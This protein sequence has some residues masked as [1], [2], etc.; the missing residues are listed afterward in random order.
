VTHLKTALASITLLFAA[1]ATEV[2]SN[3]QTAAE[4]ESLLAD[5]SS[6]WDDP[7]LVVCWVTPGFATQKQW[8]REAVENSWMR[9]TRLVF[10]GWGDCTDPT[11]VGIHITLENGA[12]PAGAPANYGWPRAE[13]HVGRDA[14]GLSDIRL[15]F[16]FQA[17]AANFGGCLTDPAAQESCIRS[18][19]A[20]EFGHA[21]GFAHEQDRRQT[22][23][24]CVAQLGQDYA[25][26]GQGIANE[27]DLGPFD[28][29]S[30]M[31]YCAS[32]YNND[33]ILSP[34]DVF[35]AQQVY[36]AKAAGS[37][38]SFDGRCLDV[39]GG[40][41]NGALMQTYEC[42]GGTHFSPGGIAAPNQRWAFVPS[43][44]ILGLFN[45]TRVLDVPRNDATSGNRLQLFD[46]LGTPGQV[47]TMPSVLLR[48]MGGMCVGPTNA[49]TPQFS[50]LALFKCDPLAPSAGMTF[51]VMPNG[52]LVNNA[53]GLC[54]HATGGSG[55]RL[56]L[57]SCDG[58]S[59]QSF[60][61]T[62]NGSLQAFA[63]TQNLCLDVGLPNDD[64]GDFFGVDGTSGYNRIQLYTCNNQANQ[65][66][67]FAGPIVGQGGKCIDVASFG[68]DNGTAVQLW[69]CNGAS[70]QVW[71]LSW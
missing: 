55:A 56:E 57:Q 29:E 67:S 41:Q 2:D 32:T 59:N 17:Q 3:P 66:F 22:S 51:N 26:A 18:I 16:D 42:L 38:V 19:A 46:P 27:W 48:G 21:L 14:A 69:D 71:E 10:A 4:P 45:S 50:E 37:L 1:C 35:Y 6:I 43:T 33:G 64:L 47:W 61:L 58:T 28:Q 15:T 24:T 11:A 12:L 39:A 53:S 25:G 36:G 62:A 31:A 68:R 44:S 30:I 49:S 8:V 9:N 40:D 23:V 34:N 52:T 20:H 63:G 7:Y 60:Q 65:Q 54:L 5:R 13:G 70:N